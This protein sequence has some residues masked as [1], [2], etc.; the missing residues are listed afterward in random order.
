MFDAYQ[1]ISENTILPDYL[2]HIFQ[3]LNY[4]EKLLHFKGMNRVHN[5]DILKTLTIKCSSKMIH[6]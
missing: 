6:I 5:F 4:R 3:L 2:R 1:Y